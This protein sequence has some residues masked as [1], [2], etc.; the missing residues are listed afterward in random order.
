MTIETTT[1]VQLSDIKAIG[2]ECSSCHA[3]TVQPIERFEHLPARCPICD[4]GQWLIHGDQDEQNL[5]AMLRAMQRFAN[6]K[7][8]HFSI[9]FTLKNGAVSREAD[10]RV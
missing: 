9:S 5:K 4:S 6:W 3:K 1:T 7:N 10:D 8:P 2:F